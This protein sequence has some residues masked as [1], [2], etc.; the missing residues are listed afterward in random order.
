MSLK[1]YLLWHAL[2]AP[3]IPHMFALGASCSAGFFPNLNVTDCVDGRCQ[4]EVI[5]GRRFPL[6]LDGTHRETYT[7]ASPQRFDGRIV[8]A[9]PST[10]TV[11]RSHVFSSNARQLRRATLLFLNYVN[12]IRQGVLIDG[13]RYYVE[14]TFVGD[15]ASL[16]S[17]AT[18]TATAARL[19]NLGIDDS[20]KGIFV[21]SPYSSDLTRIASR[22]SEEDNLIMLSASAS[23]S[24]IYENNAM[25]FGFLPS[26]KLARAT[27]YK[28][29]RNV[30]QQIDTGKRPPQ[31]RGVWCQ[32]PGCMTTLKI[33]IIGLS[34]QCGG[35]TLKDVQG[36]AS[37]LFP[38]AVSYDLSSLASDAISAALKTFVD[39]GIT[40]VE[41]C[42]LYN[43]PDTKAIIHAMAA[44]EYNPYAII[45][46]STVLSS[47]HRAHVEAGFWEGAYILDA[48]NWHPLLATDQRGEFSNL[49]TSEFMDAYQNHFDET[50]S[51]LAAGQYA[52]LCALIAT[53]ERVGTVATSIVRKALLKISLHE[54]YDNISFNSHGQIQS[55]FAVVQSDATGN[56][57]KIDTS[58]SSLQSDGSIVF[59][60]PSWKMRKCLVTTMDRQGNECSGHG[61]CL[62]DGTCVCEANWEGEQCMTAVS[63][64]GMIALYVTIGIFGSVS[65]LIAGYFVYKMCKRRRDKI[66]AKLL[67]D[68]EDAIDYCREERKDECSDRLHKLG[69][70]RSSLNAFTQDAMKRLSEEAGVSVAYILGDEFSTLAQRR[71]GKVDP[72]FYDMKTFFFTEPRVGADLICP[73]DGKLGCAYVD[74]LFPVHRRRCSHFLSWTWAYSLSTV[75]DALQSWTNSKDINTADVSLFMCFFVNNQYRILVEQTTHGAKDLEMVFESNLLRINKVVA[76]LDTFESPVYLTRIWTIFEQFSAIR[77]GVPVTMVLPPS[78]SQ[79]LMKKFDDG[80]EGILYVKDAISCVDC[81]NAKASMP[82][83]EAAVKK[84]IEEEC[85]FAQVDDK[86]E[87]FMIRWI[88]DTVQD[89]LKDMVSDSSE[90]KQTNTKVHV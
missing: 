22:Q 78:S 6:L 17:V 32:P 76:L 3:W 40:V 89:Y 8:L 80:K 48:T 88:G 86:I 29:V 36:Y 58:S 30:A 28:A 7:T 69:W 5:C 66:I 12:D 13:K 77:L 54:F 63:M 81:K 43:Y 39:E 62:N 90:K 55:S 52:A 61:K 26:T 15:H 72:T 33:G 64:S 79:Q 45:C 59:P 50:P 1:R 73:R 10:L 70:T 4:T 57:M 83:D 34:G 85:G 25:V 74:T 87:E 49:T 21:L 18:A 37:T 60:L 38:V 35:I 46:I 84:L 68:L 19:H 2:S 82:E 71:T 75:C 51:H 67:V 9:G 53:L 41:I 11:G 47:D 56:V 27:I 20:L 23:S 16:Y 14:A 44:I 65:S 31:F 42:D 24:D